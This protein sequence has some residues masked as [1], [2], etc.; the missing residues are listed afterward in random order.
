MNKD[1]KSTFS[2]M[3]TKFQINFQNIV[4]KK[5]KQNFTNMLNR[6]KSM[7]NLTI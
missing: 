7:P 4:L 5:F 2:K 6:Q 1:V 3:Y